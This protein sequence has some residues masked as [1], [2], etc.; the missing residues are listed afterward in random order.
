MIVPIYI[1]TIYFVFVSVFL[2]IA[3]DDWSLMDK[4][5]AALRVETQIDKQLDK[6]IENRQTPTAVRQTRWRHFAAIAS[7]N[8]TS[9]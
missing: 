2:W 7:V 5:N 8:Q 6:Q 4:Q 3:K 9:M 1:G